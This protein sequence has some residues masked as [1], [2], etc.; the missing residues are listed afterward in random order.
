MKLRYKPDIEPHQLYRRINNLR[1]NTVS[2]LA[3]EIQNIKNKADE[4]VVY[5][6]DDIG[7]NLTNIN[8]LLT[9]TIKEITQGVLLNKIYEEH[10][11]EKI[12][13]IMT[14]RRYEDGCIRHEFKKNRPVSP[15]LFKPTSRHQ[16]KNRFYDNNLQDRNYNQ[17]K[18]YKGNYSRQFRLTQPNFNNTQYQNQDKE[19]FSNQIRRNQTHFNTQ[20]QNKNR[21][22]YSNQIRRNQQYCNQGKTIDQDNLGEIR[23][24]PWR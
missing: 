20:Y 18:E 15:Q 22:N 14:Q 5:Y 21:E 24:N 3:L 9:N 11:L 4:L 23:T 7:I 17:N 13:N 2:E 10:N 12:I 16:N 19:K 1:A 8:S 6:R